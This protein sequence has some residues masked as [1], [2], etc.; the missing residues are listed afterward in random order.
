MGKEKP[1]FMSFNSG[2]IKKHE[3]K[4]HAARVEYNINI[5]MDQI[6]KGKPWKSDIV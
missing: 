4:K 5:A 2:M 3:T 1:N 6:Q